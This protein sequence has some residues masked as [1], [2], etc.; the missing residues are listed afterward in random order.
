MPTWDE[1]KRQQNIKKHDID[2]K[3][4]AHI[5]DETMLTVED[6]RESYGEQRLKSLTLFQNTIVVCVIWVDRNGEEHII[7]CRRAL[8]HEARYYVETLYR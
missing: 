5:F 4:L 3:D 6:T 2:F 8:K 1:A 7:S